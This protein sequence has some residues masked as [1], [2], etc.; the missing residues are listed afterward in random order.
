[1]A[2]GSGGVFVWDFV[3]KPAT[4]R[5]LKSKGHPTPPPRGGGRDFD[6][7]HTVGTFKGITFKGIPFTCPSLIFTGVPSLIFTGVPSLIFTGVVFIPSLIFGPHPTIF[8][9]RVI[10]AQ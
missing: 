3:L 2:L 9:G 1:M 4:N 8:I 10:P 5:Q 7:D 6:L